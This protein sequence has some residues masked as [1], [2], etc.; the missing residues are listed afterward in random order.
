MFTFS[1]IRL[2]KGALWVA[3]YQVRHR[4]IHK[5]WNTEQYQLTNYPWVQHKLINVTEHR[6]KNKYCD[7]MCRT[8]KHQSMVQTY[9]TDWITQPFMS[10]NSPVKEFWLS[11]R[12]IIMMCHSLMV[13]TPITY[14]GD[15]DLKLCSIN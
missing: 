10:Q 9:L 7:K 1:M 2:S 15:S 13:N 11:I 12:Y 14:T 6:E 3:F 4:N 8:L 5:T